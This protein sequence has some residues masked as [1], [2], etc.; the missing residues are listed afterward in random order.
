MKIGRNDPCP[1]GSGL[2][3]KKCCAGNQSAGGQGNPVEPVMGELRELLKDKQFGSLDEANAFLRQHMQQRNNAT[4]DDF[5]GLSSE[6][7]HRFLHFPFESPDLASF[8]PSLDSTAQAPILSLFYLL[9]SA[10]GADGL[11]PT[12][13]GNL[14]RN[15]CREAAK[16]YWG[17]E[18]YLR[19]SRYGEM[20]SETEFRELHTTRLVAEL[21]GL[22][23]KYKG[24]FI[25]SKECRKLLAEQGPAGVYPR[26]FRAYVVDYN[27]AFQDHLE[28]IPLFQQSFLFSLYLLSRYGGEWQTSTFYEDGFLR[29]FPRL[30]D[31]VQPFGSYYSPEKVVRLSYSSRCLEKFARFMGLVEIERQGDDR[32]SEE[33]MVKKLPLLDEFVQFNL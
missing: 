4:I 23:R 5:H 12:A 24:K 7:M 10:I 21:A 2:K 13:T 9:A 20:R 26:L 29:A 32:Y 8:S 33:F 28:E 16:T 15:V 6:Q 25:L 14:P 22:I 30:L 17:A 3:Y 11:K 19:Q 31:Q 1:C 27:W 18:E